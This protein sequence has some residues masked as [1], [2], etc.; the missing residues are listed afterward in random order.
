MGT[1]RK[2]GKKGS[3]KQLQSHF[4]CNSETPPSAR[5]QTGHSIPPP[6]DVNRLTCI[7]DSHPFTGKYYYRIEYG[8][9]SPMTPHSRHLQIQTEVRRSLFPCSPVSLRSDGVDTMGF[10]LTGKGWRSS[11]NSP[12]STESLKIIHCCSLGF[13]REVYIVK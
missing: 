12:S 7:L 5:S 10:H 11:K 3:S 4:I 6:P 1:A 9:S 13:Y 8:T 2:D